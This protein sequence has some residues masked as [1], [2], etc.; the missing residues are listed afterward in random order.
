MALYVLILQS[1]RCGVSIAF[2]LLLPLAVAC[3]MF[4]LG[5]EG[6]KPGYHHELG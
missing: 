6:R 2:S 3:P 5:G 1:L 4:T